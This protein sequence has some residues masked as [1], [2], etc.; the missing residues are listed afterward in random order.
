[1]RLSYRHPHNNFNGFFQYIENCLIQVV[2]VNKE[3]YILQPMRM[4]DKTAT[5][6]DNIFS[7]NIQDNINCGNILLTMSEHFTQ[8]FSVK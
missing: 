6:I 1:M 4:T 2:K 5:V 8:F 7:N 3:L